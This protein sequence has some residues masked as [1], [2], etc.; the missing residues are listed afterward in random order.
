M[1]ASP[2]RTGKG[3]VV[4]QDIGIGIIF[5][6]FPGYSES[7]RFIQIVNQ[8]RQDIMAVKFLR[9]RPG[10][11]RAGRITTAVAFRLF[12]ITPGIDQ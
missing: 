7:V 9:V 5:I 10:A 12:S 1:A 4:R 3:I 2:G 8:F 6:I 11:R